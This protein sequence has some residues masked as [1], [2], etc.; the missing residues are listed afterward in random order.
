MVSL[1]ATMDAYIVD[2][3]TNCPLCPE[4]NFG[5][6]GFLP[7][8]GGSSGRPARS[9]ISFSLEGTKERASRLL[10]ATMYLTVVVAGYG[11]YID[12]TDASSSITKSSVGCPTLHTLTTQWGEGNGLSVDRITYNAI[13]G[14]SSWIHSSFPNEWNKRGGDF[15]ADPIGVRLPGPSNA[16]TVATFALDVEK[17]QAILKN[18][19][20]NFFGFLI[21]DDDNPGTIDFASRE[22]VDAAFVPRLELVFGDEDDNSDGGNSDNTSPPTAAPTQSPIVADT[23]T[24]ISN[25]DAALPTQSPSMD[26]EQLFSSHAALAF[27]SWSLAF[28]TGL[29]TF[30]AY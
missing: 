17:M 26:A 20:S 22:W 28:I 9:L 12:C 10:N 16:Y 6:S 19:D 11:G 13:A 24:S 25:A 2:S 15:E 21:K 5:G 27:T 3:N 23:G 8:A 29:L 30:A 1:N 4:F 7:I 18:G 14:E